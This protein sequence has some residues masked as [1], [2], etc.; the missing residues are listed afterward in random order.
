MKEKPLLPAKTIKIFMLGRFDITVEDKLV[1]ERLNNSSKMKI[2]LEY[3]L[4]HRDKPVTYYELFG[5][6]WPDDENENPI[7][8]L[9]TLLY[10][11]RNLFADS[12]HEE[13]KE[14]IISNRGTY[15]W[16]PDIECE[17]DIV[18][19]EKLYDFV[20]ED[21]LSN[22]EKIE[23]Y[24]ELIS[25]YAGDL[26]P[27]ESPELWLLPYSTYFHNLYLK[28]V[29]DMIVLLRE[30]NDNE[31][32]IEVCQIALNIDNY[33]ENLHIELIKALLESGRNKEALKQYYYVIDLHQRQLGIQPPDTIRE[34]YRQIVNVEQSMELDIDKIQKSLEEKEEQRGAFVCE[35]EIF[36]DIYQQQIRYIQRTEQPVFIA[37]IT[38][39][40]IQNKI[41]D[42]LLMDKFMKQLLEVIKISLR[43]GDTISKYSSAQFVVLLPSVNYENGHFIMERIKKYYYK[44]NVNPTII[45]SYK[46]RPLTYIQKYLE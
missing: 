32:I 8:A 4:L 46:L 24:N 2:L 41:I 9:K 18:E 25:I 1:S 27:T 12:G 13:L 3:L 21:K 10:R 28:C 20:N 6:L 19:F 22:K 37:L 39:T 16:N 26:L 36:K 7:N 14:C 35:Y 43:K 23:L 42:P 5:I 34:M 30:K 29:K 45:F 17:I 40:N 11:L 44:K 15:Q 31:K 33:Y 38:L